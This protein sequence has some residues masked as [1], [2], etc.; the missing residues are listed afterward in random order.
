MRAKSLAEHVIRER[1][2]RLGKKMDARRLHIV[3][4]PTHVRECYYAWTECVPVQTC[5]TEIA[6]TILIGG[7]GMQQGGRIL[8]GSEMPGEL[9]EWLRRE[10]PPFITTAI[11]H[12]GGFGFVVYT[13]TPKNMGFSVVDP[14]TVRITVHR[15]DNMR[16]RYSVCALGYHSADVDD[17]GH[18]RRFRIFVL[19]DVDFETGRLTGKFAACMRPHR[20][21]RQLERDMLVTSRINSHPLV[22][23][24]SHGQEVTRG[25]M[26]LAGMQQQTRHAAMVQPAD[27]MQTYDEVT[28]SMY[29]S[30]MERARLLHTDPRDQMQEIDTQ[31]PVSD[32]NP[33]VASHLIVEP[34]RSV[35]QR[36]PLAIDGTKAD[37]MDNA[38]REIY[39]AWGL[40]HPHDR[41]DHSHFADYSE[42]RLLQAITT[43]IAPLLTL[44]QDVMNILFERY[45]LAAASTVY[46]VRMA[47]AIKA[48]EPDALLPLKTNKPDARIK[49][50]IAEAR[51]AVELN[52]SLLCTAPIRVVHR[53]YENH[54]YKDKDYKAFLQRVYGLP[55]GVLEE[56][57]SRLLALEQQVKA[58]EAF[59]THVAASHQDVGKGGPG[60]DG[61]ATIS[62]K[63]RK[64][65]QS[66]N[67]MSTRTREA[68]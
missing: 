14:R 52:I 54:V 22:W 19:S 1:Y 24:Q 23:L 13:A 11:A 12:M 57:D 49:Q 66:E 32:T 28:A 47:A 4:D 10:W 63:T 68:K 35:A 8:L 9:S 26:S 50:T 60:R 39:N 20:T 6:S 38:E 29:L 62:D 2:K 43:F 67:P 48:G 27:I 40:A 46:A 25:F 7:V 51:A 15:D 45:T 3:V 64:Q 59:G 42:G 36:A 33:A 41:V 34:G 55:A 53:L 18:D 21:M 61:K 65:D 44:S 37:A 58:K 30:S 5:I 16:L 31:L 17:W 56:R